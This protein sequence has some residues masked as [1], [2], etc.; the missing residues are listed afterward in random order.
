MARPGLRFVPLLGVLFVVL[1]VVGFLVAGDTPDIDATGSV[2]RG[3]YD[4]EGKHQVSAYLVAVGAV[5]FL[6]FGAY[7]RS[8]LKDLHPSSRTTVNVVLGGAV[9]GSGGLAVGS[10]IHAALAEAANKAQVSD[11]A[12]QALNALD[13][14]SF[15][16]FAVGFAAFALA[17][18]VALLRGRAF[19]PSWLA[20]AAIVLGVL[21]LIPFTGFFAALATAIWILVVSLMLF[22]RW[23]AVEA[24]RGGGPARGVPPPAVS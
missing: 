24:L 2:I 5:A 14:W 8:V 11:Q 13:S 23:E 3:D 12:L 15:Y 22:S 4:N 7:W 10:L 18:G 17:S 16:P 21:Q 20:W 9:V 6:F 19:L 1:V